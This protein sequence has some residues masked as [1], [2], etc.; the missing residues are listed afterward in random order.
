[1]KKINIIGEIGI[2]HNGDINI[3]KELILIAKSAG[4]DY[5]KFQKRNPNVCVPEKQKNTVKH[6]PWGEMTYLD[7]KLKLEFTEKE[8]IEID[9]YCSMLGIK[10]FV[11]VWD[12]DSVD[13][14][15]QI[16]FKSFDGTLKIPS[17]LIT[18]I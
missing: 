13:F 11:S 7:Y 9:N 10:W 6:T 3:T 18:D 5:V 17:A 2:N 14:M 15:N 16:N 12:K 8:Y 4:C 1:M